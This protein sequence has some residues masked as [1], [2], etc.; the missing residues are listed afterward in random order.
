[1]KKISD[2]LFFHCLRQK[3]QFRVEML[4]KFILFLCCVPIAKKVLKTNQTKCVRNFCSTYFGFMS[5]HHVTKGSANG[6]TLS[7]LKSTFCFCARMRSPS[8]GRRS[9]GPWRSSTPTLPR[10][11][12]RYSKE[13]LL[14]T[15]K[16]PA[17][18][19]S[20]PS[21]PPLQLL[22]PC[23]GLIRSLR[24][25]REAVFLCGTDKNREKKRRQCNK[26]YEIYIVVVVDFAFFYFHCFLLVV[27]DVVVIWKS[28]S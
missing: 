18:T 19:A 24:T 4:F 12:R 2:Q 14:K 15:K 16:V 23:P 7:K 28:K 8:P 5:R 27:D 6:R 26:C 13:K 9:D 21:H 17:R 25:D 1:M 11:R 3:K 20:T 22:P 10:S